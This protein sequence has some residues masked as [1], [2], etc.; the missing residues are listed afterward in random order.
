MIDSLEEEVDILV[1]PSDTSFAELDLEVEVLSLMIVSI[2]QCDQ[3]SSPRK[4]GLDRIDEERR[5]TED[6]ENPKNTIT[7]YLV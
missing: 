5:T 7:S 3:V 4:K 2:F 1:S 6:A